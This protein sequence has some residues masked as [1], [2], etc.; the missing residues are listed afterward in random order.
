MHFREGPIEDLALSLATS[1]RTADAIKL[2][3]MD[4]EFFPASPA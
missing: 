3:E 1:G 4:Q 2:L